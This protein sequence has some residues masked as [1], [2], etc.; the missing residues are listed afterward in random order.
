M[1]RKKNNLL[2]C[3]IPPTHKLPFRVFSTQKQL[4]MWLHFQSPIWYSSL[5]AHLQTWSWKLGLQSHGHK[6]LNVAQDLVRTPSNMIAP[7]QTW[8]TIIKTCIIPVMETSLTKEMRIE[9]KDPVDRIIDLK[10]KSG[11]HDVPSFIFSMAWG[12]HQIWP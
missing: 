2:R 1:H 10:H 11:I 5:S 8:N 4:I 6:H 12:W 7:Y 9:G 3:H